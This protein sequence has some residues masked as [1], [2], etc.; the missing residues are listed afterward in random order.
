MR[1]PFNTESGFDKLY[2][3]GRASH[4]NTETIKQALTGL[5]PTQPIIWSSDGWAVANGPCTEHGSC[6]L[7]HK[8]PADDGNRER[9][10]INVSNGWLGNFQVVV[11]RYHR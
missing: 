4:G 8:F 9:C 2:V 11:S 10:E 3:N 1:A 7:S 5:V 6:M